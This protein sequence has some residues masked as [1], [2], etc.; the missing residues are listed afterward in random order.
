MAE[1]L[2]VSEI[3]RGQRSEGSGYDKIR[4][5]KMQFRTTPYPVPTVTTEK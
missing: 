3:G 4:L 1:G 5:A 2:T